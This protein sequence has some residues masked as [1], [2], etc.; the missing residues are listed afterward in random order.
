MWEV[1]FSSRSAKQAKRLPEG[2][3]RVLKVLVRDLQLH[4]PIASKWPNFGKLKDKDCYH[5]H[6]KKGHPTYVAFWKVLES[7]I[8]LIEVKFV[9]THE[10]A[11]YRS[12]C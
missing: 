4:G 7:E 1:K 5:C 6:L 8:K 10:S 12:L 11:D 2:V 9:G 3:R